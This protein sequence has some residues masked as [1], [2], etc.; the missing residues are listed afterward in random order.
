LNSNGLGNV[1]WEEVIGVLRSIIP[2]YDRVNA[3]ISL[4]KDDKF[5]QEGIIKSVK[6]GDVILDAG[7]G[8][9][10]MS[11]TVLEFV[12]NDIT[13]F[14]YDPIFEMLTKVKDNIGK[15]NN[16]SNFFLF[17]GIFEQM[18]FKSNT[19]DDV[20]C[21]YSIRDAIELDDAFKEIHR[22]LKKNGRFVIVDLGK[23]D[24]FF[25]RT[26]VTLYLRYFLTFLAF[27][28]AGK[29]GFPFNTLYG[30]F[31]RWP[32]NQ[33]LEK[34]LLKYFSKVDFQKK[35]FGGAIIVVAYK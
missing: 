3:V 6:P 12:S 9:G 7:S 31:L 8:Y 35:F 34:L 15:I 18:P 1:Y 27:F 11:K 5:R 16:F 29:K 26:L 2:V 28:V 32:K 21:G 20:L 22:V 33:E 14:F 23:P 10:N 30:T 25:S 24:N 19:F 4:G 13:I 17:R